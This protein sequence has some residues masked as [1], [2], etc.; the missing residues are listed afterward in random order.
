[1]RM[2]SLSKVTTFSKS[3][4]KKRKNREPCGLMK[5]ETKATRHSASSEM[6]A[7]LV[8]G[9]ASIKNKVSYRPQKT[10]PSNIKDRIKTPYAAK[11]NHSFGHRHGCWV[12]PWQ[13]RVLT[14][15][16]VGGEQKM[17]KKLCFGFC[18]VFFVCFI[19]MDQGNGI[20]RRETPGPPCLHLRNGSASF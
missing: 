4:Q 13:T 16:L 14:L 11:H 18:W 2:K 3:E 10:C 8:G 17:T 20:A 7:E 19:I 9:R 12:I 15:V 5:G 1:M 6:V